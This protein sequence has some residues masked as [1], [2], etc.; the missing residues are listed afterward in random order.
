MEEI[1]KNRYK[2]LIPIMLAGIMATADSG[3]LNV[4][5]PTFAEVFKVKMETVSWISSAYLLVVACFLLTAG[6]LGDIHGYKKPFEWGVLIFTVGTALCGF[7]PS[8]VLLIAARAFQGVGTSL[9]MAAIPAMVISYFPPKERGKAM[10]L[11]VVSVSIGLAL[12]PSLGGLL[13]SRF[14]WRCIFFINIPLGIAALL[15]SK[16]FIPEKLHKREGGFDYKGTI[17]AFI[18]LASLLFYINRGSSIGWMSKTS[19]ILI[20]TSIV[21]FT[22]FIYQEGK[23]R[24]PMLDMSLFSSKAFVAG[25]VSNFMYFFAQFVMV[26]LTPFLL[27]AANY[28]PGI[29]GLTVT[30]FPLTMMVFAPLGGYL[31][32]K[33]NP[34]HISAIGGLIAGVS[35]LLIGMLPL[36][37]S[38]IDVVWRMV[39]FGIGGGLFETSNSIVVLSNA[40]EHRRGIAS[41]VLAMVR[42]M[43]MVFGV[44]ISSTLSSLRSGYHLET[45]LSFANDGRDIAAIKGIKDV[46]IIA[47]ACTLACAIAA[48]I[49]SVKYRGEER[50]S[51]EKRSIR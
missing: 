27:T 18:F 41:G 19:L 23:A 46:F 24:E 2:I 48:F 28:S 44:A 32:D 15:T 35:V 17:L 7:A 34:N 25:L 49:G 36:S 29:I 33:V 8:L 1:M 21:S 4:A 43:G 37:F 13:L 47:F 38:I 16:I 50:L 42:N 5:M 20:L 51:I 39:I 9:F 14:I 22:M 3:V 30:A 40:P 26:F 45:L 11:Y 6:R 12:G 10:G 31:S